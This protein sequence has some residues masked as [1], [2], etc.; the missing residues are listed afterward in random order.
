MSGK[1]RQEKGTRKGSRK[2]PPRRDRAEDGGVSGQP[3]TAHG[4]DNPSTEEQKEPI[5][6]ESSYDRRKEEDK[7]YRSR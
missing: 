6:R 1:E 5:D 7:E 2:H 4:E 3:A